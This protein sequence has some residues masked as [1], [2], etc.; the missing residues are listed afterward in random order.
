MPVQSR[1]SGGRLPLVDPAMLEGAQK[2]L[3]DAINA[4]MVPWADAAPFRSK[5]TDGRLIGPFN[6]VLFSPEIG[7]VFL[8]LQ[9]AE[10]KHTA[11]SERVRQVII[12]TVGSVWKAPY[13][14][15]AHAAVAR[16]A[17]LSD[18]TVRALAAGRSSAEL[19]DEER[20][21]QQFTR[22]LTAERR[23]DDKVYQAA[24]GYL[25]EKG[26]VDMVMLAGCYH[27]VCSMLNAFAVP[28]PQ[29][30]H[31]FTEEL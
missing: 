5:T 16:K 27:V 10:Q 24:A 12:L 1:P 4:T 6:A 28:A 22:Q 9:A 15:Y 8:A 29:P 23:V 7:K 11:L 13:E 30:D 19:S 26:L 25:D 2:D 18:E 3:Y 14:L 21:A 20:A 17:G 31:R